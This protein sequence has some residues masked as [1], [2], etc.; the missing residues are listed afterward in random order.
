MSTFRIYVNSIDCQARWT[1]RTVDSDNRGRSWCRFSGSRPLGCEGSCWQTCCRRTSSSPPCCHHLTQIIYC[2]WLCLSPRYYYYCYYGYYCPIRYCSLCC[3]DHQ[4]YYCGSRLIRCSYYVA[5]SSIRI[6]LRSASPSFSALSK[7][8]TTPGRSLSIYTGSVP[9]Y[10]HCFP[11][12][13]IPPSSTPSSISSPTNCRSL[14]TI[15][16]TIAVVV[17]SPA[18]YSHL[19][20]RSTRLSATESNFSATTVIAYSCSTDPS[21]PPSTY[22]GSPASSLRNKYLGKPTEIFDK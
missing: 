9:S 10:R 12:S 17:P 11:T 15:R 6:N 7:D 5:P 3:W 18:V 20:T 22:S 4:W 21:A 16:C 2:S 1:V 14:P 8:Q 13:F 19:L